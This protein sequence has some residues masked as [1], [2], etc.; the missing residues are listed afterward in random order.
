MKNEEWKRE[1]ERETGER[2]K[3]IIVKER[4]SKKGVSGASEFSSDVLF[5]D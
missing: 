3:C 2:C 4:E 5:V 1:R